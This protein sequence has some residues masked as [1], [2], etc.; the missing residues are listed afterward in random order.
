MACGAAVDSLATVSATSPSL[1]EGSSAVW[2]GALEGEEGA[3]E[4]MPPSS[5]FFYRLDTCE[6]LLFECLFVRQF[7]LLGFK[8][9]V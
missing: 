5:F 2:A 7:K 4:A 6:E 9:S 1:I 8:E 3:E